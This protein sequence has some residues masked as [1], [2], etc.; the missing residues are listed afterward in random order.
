VSGPSGGGGRRRFR[1]VA[2]LAA[3]SIAVWLLWDTVFAW[4]VQMFVVLLHE[5]SHGVV[6]IATG[7]TIREIGL[8]PDQ[9]GF[10]RCPGGSAFLTLS[11]GYLGSLAWGALFI[12]V[13]RRGGLVSRGLLGVLGAG[14]LVLGLTTVRA[15]FALLL[16]LVT[17]AA[18][19]VA[20]FRLGAG[21][22]KLLLT[23]LG[24]TSCLYAVL[25]IKSDILDRPGLASDAT[26]LARMTGVPAAVWGILW[27]LVSL[28]VCGWLLRRSW[29]RA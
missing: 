19:E 17:G 6:A 11:A 2:G 3:Y 24:L 9:G 27:I 25:D 10:C 14:I 4:P 13:G 8:S 20:A 1:L 12:E 5:L 7:G 29:S 18:L 23:A 22:C 26:A 21:G 15:P 28:G 16:C